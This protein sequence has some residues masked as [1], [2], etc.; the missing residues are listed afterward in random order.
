MLGVALIAV[1]LAQA[2]TTYDAV[3]DRGPRAKPALVNPGPA[4]SSFKDPVFGSRI[5]RVTDRFTRSDK[6][7]ASYRTPSASIQNAWS[8]NDSFFFVVSTDGT[9]VSFAFDPFS[10]KATRL[11]PLNFYIEPEF[12]Y[13]SD[14]VIYGS[15]S[16]G[17]LHTIDRRRGA[18]K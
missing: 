3:T 2:P 8:A 11:S 15:V 4:G 14:T 16:S 13:V 6:L 1:V 18:R 17:S 12:S 9:V 10:G 5:S 7:D